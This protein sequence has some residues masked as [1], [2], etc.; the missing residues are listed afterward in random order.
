MEAGRVQD[1]PVITTERVDDI[2]LLIGVMAQMELPRI[3]DR[4]LPFHWK[5]RTL[6]W[7]WTAVVWLAYILT[8]GDHRK[9]SVEEYIKGMKHTLKEVVG[10]AISEADF[11]TDRLAHVL[12]YLSQESS[13]KEIEQELSERSIEVYDL[14]TE[15]A[16]CDATTVSGYHTG[17][18]GDLFQFGHSKDDPNL[19]QIKLMVGSL[20]PLGMPLATAVVSGEQADDGLYVPVIDRMH[21]ILKK[22]GVLF[23]GDCKMSAFSI[24]LHI[25]GLGNHYLSPLPLTGKTATEMDQWIQEGMAQDA[26]GELESVYRK[27]ETTTGKK[28]DVLIARGYEWERE[29]TGQEG[30]QEIQWTERVLVVQSPPYAEQQKKGLDKRVE[31]ARKKIL[32]LTPPRGRGKR[33]I[34]E[35]T[36]LNEKIHTILTAHKVDGLLAVK[37][38][39]EVEEQVKYIGQGRGAKNRPQ[40]IIQKIRYQITQ[41][42]PLEEKLDAKKKTLGWKAYVTDA[43]KECLSLQEAVLC[44]RKEYRVERI[45]NRLK[46]HL[47]IAP[48]FVQRED[49]VAGLT[50]LLT[51]GVRVLTLIEFVVRRSLQQESVSLEGLH[52]ENPRKVTDSPTAER[53]LKV[54]S[55]IHLTLIRSG[56]SLLRHLTPLS[57]VQ[58]KILKILGLDSGLYQNIEIKNTGILLTNW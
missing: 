16:R 44:Y 10:Q 58:K 53:I 54:F 2:P 46:S 55:K 47:N 35:E 18:E 19:R 8:E 39:K 41:A 6:S 13:W 32:A 36:V 43:E 51:L 3:L 52:P 37:Y 45:F 22:T 25:K 21:Q 27:K 7:G 30:S 5:Q 57:E 17:G 14:S 38:E 42:I 15:L 4:H 1:P 31:N 33:Q 50:H 26:R 34:T 56:N 23:C 48:F 12:K 28:E 11:T 40:Q 29:Q 9:S 20:D 24:R 49:Q